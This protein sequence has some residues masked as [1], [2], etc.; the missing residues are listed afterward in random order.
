MAQTKTQIKVTNLL[1]P[2]RT[3]KAEA[4][5][6]ARCPLLALPRSMIENWNCHLPETRAPAQQTALSTGARR[7]V[8]AR[9]VVG[10]PLGTPL[11]NRLGI[12]AERAILVPVSVFRYENILHLIMVPSSAH[13]WQ[14]TDERIVLCLHKIQL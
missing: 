5:V 9:L 11:R 7:H 14:S 10:L 4:I 6:D 2:D 3:V 13:H 1:K 12:A 8:Y